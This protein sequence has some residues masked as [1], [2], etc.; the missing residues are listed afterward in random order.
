M[1]LTRFVSLP[2]GRNDTPSLADNFLSNGATRCDQNGK[3]LHIVQ[4]HTLKTKYRKFGPVLLSF[5][6]V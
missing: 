3:S 4:F 5:I 1:I 6:P 2:V